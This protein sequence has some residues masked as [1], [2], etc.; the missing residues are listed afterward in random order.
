MKIKNKT[1]ETITTETYEM[2]VNGC[3]CVYIDYLNQKGKC[4]DAVLRDDA[5]NNVDDPALMEQIQKEV[6][7]YDAN[8]ELYE[9]NHI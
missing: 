9:A 6:D 5:G 2:E 1:T 8:P 4:I 3:R 7:E